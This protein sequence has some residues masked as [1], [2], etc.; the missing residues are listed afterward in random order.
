MGEGAVWEVAVLGAFGM[1]Q[2]T[3]VR[4]HVQRAAIQVRFFFSYLTYLCTFKH[5][6]T[7]ACVCSI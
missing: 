2:L 4:S 6:D 5:S 3:L 7:T 1:G